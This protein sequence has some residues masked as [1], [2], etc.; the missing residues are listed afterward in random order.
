MMLFRQFGAALA[1]QPDIKWNALTEEQASS[2]QAAYNTAAEQ[3]TN[4]Q[5]Q[6][7]SPYL[8]REPY[9]FVSYA[10][11]DRD[12]VMPVL[13]ELLDL[14]WRLWWDEE[15]PGGADWHA[16]L[17]SRIKE[18]QN[19]MVFVSAASNR[20]KW[21]AEEIRLAHDFGKPILSIR[22]D[23][24]EIPKETLSILGRYQMLDHAAVNFREQLGRGM[25][26]LQEA[27]SDTAKN[28]YPFNGALRG[29]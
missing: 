3:Y 17:S 15:I 1:D 2:Y 7:S 18:T 16:Y 9:T 25:H 27:T 21:V 23:W 11:D 8:G 14:E 13:Q 29:S 22:L 5:F 20:S 19:V 4:P 6:V 28:K 24:S 26:F 12:V 10:R